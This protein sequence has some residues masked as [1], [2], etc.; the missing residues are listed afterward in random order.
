MNRFSKLITCLG[1]IGLMMI[2]SSS[3]VER[4]S[5]SNLPAT[6]RPLVKEH[7][8]G[9]DRPFAQGHASTVVQTNDHKYLVAWFG[10]THEKHDD[11]GIWLSKGSPSNWSRPMEVA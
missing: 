9:D 8:F 3:M 11:V 6:I 2:T 1:L 7:I 4:T 5:L 10:G